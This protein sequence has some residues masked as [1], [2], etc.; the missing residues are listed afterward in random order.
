MKDP[1]EAS[2]CNTKQIQISLVF[3]AE[4]S[5]FSAGLPA[6]RPQSYNA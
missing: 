4:L 3:A 6:L 1:K 5:V 2:G